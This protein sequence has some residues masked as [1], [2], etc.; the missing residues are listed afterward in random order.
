MMGEMDEACTYYHEAGHFFADLVRSHVFQCASFSVVAF[1]SVWMAIEIDADEETTLQVVMANV[2]CSYF[3]LELLA[4]ILAFRC[5]RDFLRDMAFVFDALL[6]L[7]VVA[8]TWL[9]PLVHAANGSR[10][11]EG[12]N[13]RIALVFRLLRFLKVLRLGKVLRQLP[14]LLIIVRG[15]LMAYKAISFTI[16]LL[17]MIVYAGGLVFRVLLDGTALGADSF[18]TV[19]MAMG[20]LLIEATLSGSR[21][22]SLLQETYSAHPACAACML[23]YIVLANITMMGVLGGLLVQAVKTVTEFEKAHIDFVE[24]LK[25]LNVIWTLA[26]QHDNNK[27]NCICLQ[28]FEEI[29]ADSESVRKLKSAGVDMESLAMCSGFIFEQHGQDGKLTRQQF[30]QCVLDHQG[31]QAAK[32][33]DHVQT[34]RYMHSQL[35]AF[36]QAPPLPVQKFGGIENRTASLLR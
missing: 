23:L 6:V 25:D 21:G 19:P 10:S 30:M 22:G 34:R 12:S 28:E 33:K 2:L 11:G 27:D 9:I 4:Q 8:E 1:S 32:V 18:A 3:G 36:F 26:L 20:T 17:A 15:V 14:E 24:L 16:L 5:K 31:K 29:M 13:M 7:L 35:Q